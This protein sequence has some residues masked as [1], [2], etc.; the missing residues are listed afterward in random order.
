MILSS[1]IFPFVASRAEL[2]LL[3]NYDVL[4]PFDN[5]DTNSDFYTM[6]SEPDLEMSD[7]LSQGVSGL[8]S[9]PDTDLWAEASDQCS[10]DGQST[11]NIQR[12]IDVCPGVG[13]LNEAGNVPNF[14]QLR[15]P[16]ALEA[17]TE[18]AQTATSDDIDICGPTNVLYARI[19]A[20]CDS[21]FDDDRILNKITGEYALIDCERRKLKGS[22]IAQ[23]KPI[24]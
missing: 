20:A 23:V 18:T 8:V 9:D 13:S 7:Q 4:E 1:F 5:V 6:D 10:T 3:G 21:G 2:S 19:F 14:D 22:S 17:G 15:L 24:V 12:R 16:S 11:N